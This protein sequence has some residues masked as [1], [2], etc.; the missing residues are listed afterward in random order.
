MLFKG[1][2]K[3]LDPIYM[4]L[5][6]ART[7]LSLARARSTFTSGIHR[8]VPAKQPRMMKFF[9]RIETPDQ[10]CSKTALTCGRASLAGNIEIDVSSHERNI[11]TQKMRSCWPDL[12]SVIMCARI[13]RH[14]FWP[15][16]E[17]KMKRINSQH[18]CV[19][20]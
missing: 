13:Q 17:K 9:G 15:E 12:P 6:T 11:I 4:G 20:R 14:N 8:R 5:M 3:A 16:K 7:C 19:T 10:G 18:E 1:V 2:V